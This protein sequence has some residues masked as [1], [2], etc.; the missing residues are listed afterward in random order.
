MKPL[1]GNVTGKTPRLSCAFLLRLLLFCALLGLLSCALLGSIISAIFL[2]CYLFT[3][4]Q[5]IRSLG[6]LTFDL[7]HLLLKSEEEPFSNFRLIRSVGKGWRFKSLN[8]LHFVSWKEFEY[9]VVTDI[10]KGK[11]TPKVAAGFCLH[12]STFKR[13]RECQKRGL[14]GREGRMLR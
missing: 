3:L 12:I 13:L 10:R 2:D 8:Q 9:H 7:F 14:I 6:A 5:L 1:H 11:A 4:F